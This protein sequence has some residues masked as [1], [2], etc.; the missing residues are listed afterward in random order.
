M[1]QSDKTKE[2]I[3]KASLI[4]GDKYDYSKVQYK[5]AIEKVIIIC[6]THDEFS[7]Q[8]NLHLMGSGCVECFREG[9]TL[10]QRSNKEEF[11][12]KAK[13]KHGDKYDYSK[14]DY[15]TSNKKVIIICKKHDEFQQTPAKHLQGNG[16]KLCGILS[17]TVK[18][19]SNTEEFIEKAKQ[20]HGDKYDYSKVEYTTSNK[21]L[22][23]ICKQHGQFPQVANSHLQGHGCKICFTL[24]NSNSQRSN[25]EEFIKKAKEKHGDKYDYS[26]VE[27]TSSK[28]DMIIICKEHGVFKQEA[29]GH[30]QG[31][32]CKTCA[33]QLIA[34][35]QRSNTEEFIKKAK[36]K[37]GDKYDYS[38]VEYV[39]DRS[40]VVITCKVHG[41]FAQTARDHLCG[42]GCSKC[43][44]VYRKNTNEYIEDAKKVHGDKYDYSKTIFKRAKDKIIIT[45]KKHGDFEQEA[46]CH[47]IGIGCSICMNKTEAKLY[48][49]IVSIFP[50]LLKQFRQEWCINQLSKTNKYLPFDF[51]IPEYKIIIELDGPQ[52][53]IQI[54]NWKTPEEQFENDKFKEECA[55][56]NGYSV[57]RL[58]QEAVMNDT[59]DW[60]KELC[61]AIEEIKTR[62][63][64]TNVYLSKNNEYDNF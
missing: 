1:E 6:K 22:I 33:I 12:K 47:S 40:K 3:H 19:S 41:G 62:N 20:V 26:K 34:N 2:F 64:I 15:T 30:L 46:Y 45:C 25:T 18:R 42:C 27:Y 53:F 13:K 52:H 57:I 14:V 21:E 36:E 11:I 37:H 17:Q 16:C 44:K 58:L 7:Q 32:G 38:K 59:Y 23:I 10:L 28:E 51:C 54:M 29:Q 43:G 24:I 61:D 8:A 56:N 39:K 31:H 4:H 5:K 9:N 48:E 49:N 63:E 55:N 50:S 60:V 35:S